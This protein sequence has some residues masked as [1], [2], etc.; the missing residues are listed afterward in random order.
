MG[1]WFKWGALGGDGWHPVH[2]RVP[3]VER[4]LT[5]ESQT[6]EDGDVYS[7]GL[8]GMGWFLT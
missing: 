6:L 2:W 4:S 5:G 3:S 8:L 1:Q 7:V